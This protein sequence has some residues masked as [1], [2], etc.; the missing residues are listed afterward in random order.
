MRKIISLAALTLSAAVLM[1]LAACGGTPAKTNGKSLYD[2]G[3]ELIAQMDEMAES[4]EYLNLYSAS[5]EL[6]AIAS[7]AAQG[8]FSSPK[9]VYKLTAGGDSMLHLTEEAEAFNALPE[10]LRELVRSRLFAAL[11][12]QINAQAGSTTLAASSICTAGKTFVSTELTEN[13]IY[14]YTFEN[15]VPAA[16]TF[17]MGED[18]S[19]SASACFILYD[20]LDG[21]IDSFS[22]FLGGLGLKIEEIELK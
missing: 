22:Q 18:S 16:V 2:H 1:G 21:S 6:N 11:V 5:A 14:I 9:A 17:T 12:T 3:L 13:M 20:G 7:E 10:T 19:V 4:E 15:A 8:D